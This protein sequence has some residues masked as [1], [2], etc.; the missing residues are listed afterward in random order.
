MPKVSPSSR[1]SL[2]RSCGSSQDRGVRSDL[3]GI[4]G[5]IAERSSKQDSSSV[6]R[7]RKAE[8]DVG[9]SHV[10]KKSEVAASSAPLKGAKRIM[11]ESPLGRGRP[12]DIAPDLFYVFSRVF[13]LR[14]NHKR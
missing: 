7:K 6:G 14:R 9:S 3:K 2:A 10:S 8:E 4:A 1:R 5:P 11:F 13:A 12:G